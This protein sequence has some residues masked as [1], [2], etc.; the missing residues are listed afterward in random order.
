MFLMRGVLG[1]AGSEVRLDID[2][3]VGS[4]SE[5]Q[6]ASGGLASIESVADE[7][8]VEERFQGSGRDY[9][10]PC[11]GDGDV[12]VDH[13]RKERGL[14]AGCGDY[15]IGGDV[16]SGCFDRCDPVVFNVDTGDGGVLV[17]SAAE[18]LEC[19]CECLDRTLGIGVTAVCEEES[20]ESPS[21]DPGDHVANLRRIKLFHAYTV[22]QGMV[23]FLEDVAHLLFGH[24]DLD[25]ALMNEL[26]GIA[27]FIIERRPQPHGFEGERYKSGFVG[28]LAD[29]P[30]VSTGCLAADHSLFDDY[31]ILAGFGEEV[32]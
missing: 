5:E 13:V 28:A 12:N 18:V 27:E 30:A 16:A 11:W 17:E 9:F 25:P 2:P 10:Y 7:G 22:V 6:I 14:G 19:P 26:S 3:L 32:G 15:E 1:L 20:A 4:A 23:V 21:G 31:D 8:D 24:C 29:H